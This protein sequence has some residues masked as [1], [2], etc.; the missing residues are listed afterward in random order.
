MAVTWRGSASRQVVCTQLQAPSGRVR[1]CHKQIPTGLHHTRLHHTR[2]Q[3]GPL[4]SPFFPQFIDEPPQPKY[5]N[6]TSKYALPDT[7]PIDR[8]DAVITLQVPYSVLHSL[9]AYRPANLYRAAVMYAAVGGACWAVWSTT[10]PPIPPLAP[11]SL[12]SQDGQFCPDSQPEWSA[13]REASFGFG[14]LEILNETHAT[15]EWKRNA[16]LGGG[17][18]G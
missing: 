16:G 7:Q 5:C 14:V 15:W 18:G 3:P 11:L 1:V 13:F 6:K 8:P 2:R 4:P 10:D 12:T 9:T 17:Q